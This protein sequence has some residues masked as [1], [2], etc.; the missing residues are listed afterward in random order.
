MSIKGASWLSGKRLILKA[1]AIVG[2]S[3]LIV[4][5]VL[6]SIQG[7][8][9]TRGI[10]EEQKLMIRQ[11]AYVVAE[12]FDA[13]IREAATLLEFYATNPDTAAQYLERIIDR[14]PLFASV[15]IMDGASGT[16]VHSSDPSLE[17]VFVGA[18]PAFANNFALGT[19]TFIDPYPMQLSENH[20]VGIPIGVRMDRSNG[21]REFLVGVIGSNEMS[22]VFFENLQVS[23]QGYPF[24]VDRAG[25]IVGHPSH[26]L[27]GVN[28]SEYE[29]IQQMTNDTLKEGFLG[30]MWNKGDDERMIHQKY[31]AFQRMK[32]LEWIVG[33]TIYEEDLLSVAQRITL[34]SYLLAFAALI[35]ISIILSVFLNRAVISR[36]LT[37]NAAVAR[38]AEGDLTTRIE[39]RSKDEITEMAQGLNQLFDSI[40]DAVSKLRPFVNTHF[41]AV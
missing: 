3:V 39:M 11:Q 14:E 32:N 27:H 13:R 34:E 40:R 35:V 7:Q 41:S 20:E 29:F 4:F 23:R 2:F 24:I 38:A 25:T 19:R 18:I 16:V 17:G 21:K 37:I 31:L 26:A 30:Y 33:V 9:I 6:F 22:T 28:L 12:L 5:L 36:F 10:L 8:L 15:S 1:T